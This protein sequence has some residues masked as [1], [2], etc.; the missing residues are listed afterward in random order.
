MVHFLALS[1]DVAMSLY[2][3]KWACTTWCPWQKKTAGGGIQGLVKP[4]L[5]HQPRLTRPLVSNDLDNNH[6][7]DTFLTSLA[8]DT[9]HS[10]NWMNH[11]PQ[12]LNKHADNTLPSFRYD[13]WHASWCQE[14]VAWYNTVIFLHVLLSTAASSL[15]SH[16]WQQDHAFS[17]SCDSLN[18]A[19]LLLAKRLSKCAYPIASM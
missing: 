1:L 7:F 4:S 8:H 10:T 14:H 15:F 3:A 9:T 13:L 16:S 2:V 6:F 5:Q 19:I 18:I 11:L 12:L 17:V